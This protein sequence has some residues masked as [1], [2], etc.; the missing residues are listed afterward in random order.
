[1]KTTT[2]KDIS[3]NNKEFFSIVIVIM[4]QLMDFSPTFVGDINCFL[5]NLKGNSTFDIFTK[6]EKKL[7]KVVK[8]KHC[9]IGT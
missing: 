1:M 3:S 6:L 8:S 4:Y 7:T 9:H 2:F 5:I